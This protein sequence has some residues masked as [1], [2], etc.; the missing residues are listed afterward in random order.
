V[1]SGAKFSDNTD[2]HWIQLQRLKKQLGYDINVT[3]PEIDEL[4]N[5][6]ING[7]KI[8]PNQYFYLNYTPTTQTIYVSP[9]VKNVLGYETE[10]FEYKRL[11]DIIH[12]DDQPIVLAGTYFAYETANSK[13][14]KP[15]EFGVF[16]SYRAFHKN[17][18]LK[19]LLRYSSPIKYDITGKVI[20]YI[21]VVTDITDMQPSNRVHIWHTGL[22]DE[23]PP[24]STENFY[25]NNLLSKREMDI[26]FYLCEGLNSNG[27]AQKLFISRHTVD[28]H[29]RR[30]LAKMK[31]ENTGQLIRNAFNMGL[32][33]QSPV[34]ANSLNDVESV[35]V[36]QL[37]N[38]SR[39]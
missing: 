34:K 23:V 39:V 30:I 10:E 19:R 33:P 31:V 5:D 11:L 13:V 16:F 3:I 37:D 38:K 22:P 1:Q 18:T 7:I 35:S 8:L 15:F 26:L 21:S 9:H 36:H 29:R 12:P 17:G 25:N 20:H 24:F 27:I 4:L 28:T 2:S 32:F 6:I 14:F